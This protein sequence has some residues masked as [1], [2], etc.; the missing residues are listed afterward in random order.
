MTDRFDIS[1]VVDASP[2][3]VSSPHPSRLDDLPRLARDPAFH[4]MTATQ[5]LGAFN[6]NLFKQ[7]VLLICLDLGGAARGGFLQMV[8]QG[9]FAIAFVLFSGFAGFLSDLTSKRTIVVLAKVAEIA[10]MLLGMGA[11]FLG[12]VEPAWMLPG[13]LAVLFLMGTQSAFFGPSKYGILPEMF[14]GRDLPRVN[15]MVQMTTFA[16]IIFGTAL[17]GYAKE[18]FQADLWVVSA[19]CVGIAVLGTATSLWVRKTPVAHT[20]LRFRLSSLAIN[21]Q[22]WNML[23]SDRPLFGVLLISAVFWFVGGVMLPAVN[24]FGRFQLHVGDGRTSL[25][26]SCMGVGIAIGCAVAGKA[27]H[28]RVSFR[29]VHLGA[30]GMVAT[31]AA[32]AGLGLAPLSV[33]ALEWLARLDLMLAGFFAGLFVVPLQVFM[34]ARPPEDQKGRMIGAMNLINWIG[35]VLAAGFFGLCTWAFGEQAALARA[36][37]DAPV[38]WTFAVLALVLLPVALFYH[39]REESLE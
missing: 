24:E 15:G 34:Q 26:A 25:L 30:W 33:A 3:T 12:A 14:R 27:S 6:D 36:G 9:L 22:T 21:A 5:F 18:W 37:V 8:A 31:L 38:S 7:L 20:G 29:L 2:R 1:A 32:M 23:R 10:I 4:G 28:E 16:A 19:M 13:L 17:A 11:L 35:I 39:P